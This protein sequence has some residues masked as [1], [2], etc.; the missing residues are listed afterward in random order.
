MKSN[1]KK[2]VKILRY[3]YP[4]FRAIDVFGLAMLTFSLVF[5]S[6]LSEY[7]SLFAGIV[8]VFGILWS[9]GRLAY[10]NLCTCP[11]C[12]R[13]IEY[14]DLIAHEESQLLYCPYCQKE[15]EGK[16]LE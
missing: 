10:H 9:L 4:V 2:T 7:R 16:I 15:F 11:L 6:Y 8:V 1:A 12:L 5:P 3:T 14:K 13:K